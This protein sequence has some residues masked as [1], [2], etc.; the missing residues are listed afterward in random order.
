MGFFG[1]DARRLGVDGESKIVF[2]FGAIDGSV[3][4]GV[5]NDIGRDAANQS[6]GLLGIGK[7]TDSR[8]TPTRG[9]SR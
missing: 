4:G 2:D 3:G 6:A 9:R 8:S 1:E 5:Q 7:S